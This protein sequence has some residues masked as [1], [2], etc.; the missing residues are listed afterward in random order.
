MND[1]MMLESNKIVFVVGN[2]RSGTTMM[3]RVLGKSKGF[4]TFGELHF[5]GML[6]DPKSD[7]KSG[8]LTNNQAAKLYARL[9]CL[10]REG[11]FSNIEQSIKYGKEGLSQVTKASARSYEEVY[12]LFLFNEAHSHNKIIP[13]EQTPK[14][15]FFLENILKLPY[16]IKVVNMV[17]DPRDILSSQKRKWKRRSLGVKGIPLQEAIRAWFNYHPITISMIW[18]SAIREY[19]SHRADSDHILCVK[20]EDF[21]SK[22]SDEL[23]KIC[24][25]LNVDFDLEML[26]VP[27]VGSSDVADSSKVGIKS[28]RINPWKSN[29]V[30]LKTEIYICEKICKKEMKEMDYPLTSYKPNIFVLSYYYFIFPFKISIALLLNFKRMKKFFSIIQKYFLSRGG[31]V[32]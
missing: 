19:Q 32:S 9:V 21:L 14:N 5:Y 28:N 4:H 30:L 13:C 2:A 15:I 1:N 12:T 26:S 7:V 22:P 27:Q 17:R 24:A 3:G 16:D 23:E 29:G 6:F 31:S 18:R 25:F 8:E 10:E 20:F 11:F